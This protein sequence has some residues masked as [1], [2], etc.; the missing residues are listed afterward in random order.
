MIYIPKDYQM[1]QDECTREPRPKL[2]AHNF[3]GVQRTESNYRDEEK[4]K[5]KQSA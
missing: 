4:L 2:N 3:I 1:I 5:K